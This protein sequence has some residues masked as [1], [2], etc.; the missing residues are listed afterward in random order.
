MADM[1]IEL[2]LDNNLVLED[3]EEDS[4]IRA[5]LKQVDRKYYHRK[6]ENRMEE[7]RKFPLL[8]EDGSSFFNTYQYVE[9]GLKK[10]DNNVVK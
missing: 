1:N 5:F 4:K 3:M 2:V 8:G 7:M 10:R 6:I 9:L